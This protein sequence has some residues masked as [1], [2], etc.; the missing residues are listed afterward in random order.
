[1]IQLY[2]GFA[3]YGPALLPRLKRE[4]AAALRAGGYDSVGAAIGTDA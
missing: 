3:E 2:T 4:L 1:L